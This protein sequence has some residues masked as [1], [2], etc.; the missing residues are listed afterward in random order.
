MF[1]TAEKSIW[2]FDKTP[3]QSESITKKAKKMLK[4][5]ENL[6]LGRC[7]NVTFDLHTWRKAN[8]IHKWFVDNVQ[9]GKDDCSKWMVG[10]EDLKKLNQLI[11]EVE[12]HHKV[13]KDLLPTLEGLFFGS[14]E[15]DEWYWDELKDTKKKLDY[16][17]KN[18]DKFK[19]LEI[20]Y[21]SSW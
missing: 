9:N 19:E 10:M 13:A 16:I 5:D 12:K 6:E 14:Y 11:G 7:C 3:K 21:Q 2:T 1:L 15:Y 17:I 8:A 4:I 18:E 20:Y